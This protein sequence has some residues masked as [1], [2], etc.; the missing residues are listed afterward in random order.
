MKETLDRLHS[1][2]DKIDDRLDK[3]DKHLAIYNEQLTIHIK[4]SEM[5]EEDMKP[6]KEHVHQVKGI[7]K[8]ISIIGVIA[9]IAAAIKGAL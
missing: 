9:G 7:F 6:V 2:V 1:K 5:L 8:F 4:R 3:V